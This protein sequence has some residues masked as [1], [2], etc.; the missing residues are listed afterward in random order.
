VAEKNHR[1]RLNIPAAAPH[2]PPVSIATVLLLVP[3]LAP[4]QSRQEEAPDTASLL[5]GL[6]GRPCLSAEFFFFPRAPEIPSWA[7]PSHFPA[8]FE[9]RLFT[10]FLWIQ[11]NS[12]LNCCNFEFK[13]REI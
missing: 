4:V 12:Y 8:R 11:F 10:F 6:A 7:G 5:S 1:S 13:F 9:F 2:H 3:S